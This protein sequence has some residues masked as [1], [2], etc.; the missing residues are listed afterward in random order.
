MTPDEIEVVLEAHAQWLKD[1]ATGQRANLAGADLTGSNVAWADLRGAN[2]RGAD[3][4]GAIGYVAPKLEPEKIVCD[5]FLG[6]I[7]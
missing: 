4:T 6:E 2:L 7:R 1:P 3:L 5:F